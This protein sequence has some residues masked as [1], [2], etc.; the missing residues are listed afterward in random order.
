MILISIKRAI[1]A[2]TI[3]KTCAFL[4]REV[5][6]QLRVEREIKRSVVNKEIIIN[7]EN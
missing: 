3:S 6:W 2:P 5:A 7:E 4:T 1:A